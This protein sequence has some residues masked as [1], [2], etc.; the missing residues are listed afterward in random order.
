MKKTIMAMATVTVVGLSGVFFTDTIHAA[1]DLKEIKDERSE[2]KENLTDAESKIADVLIDLKEINEEIKQSE[3]SLQAN[4]EATEDVQSEMDELNKEIDVLEDAIEERFDILKERA[5]SYQRSGGNIAYLDVI[6]GSSSF[7]EFISRVSAV[8]KIADS[9]A[10][11]IE[12]QEADKAEVEQKLSEL[13]DLK[14]EL[15]E[16]EQLILEQKEANE[17]RKKELKGKEKELKQLKSK[18]Q[19]KD[20]KLAAL[21]SEIYASMQ[22]AKTTTASKGSGGSSKAS[23][24][25]RSVTGGGA[26]GWPTQGGYISSHMGTRGGRMHKGMD[27]ART[28]RSTSP[29]IFAADGG[30]VASA[31]HSGAY[32]NKVVIN[33]NNGMKT[34]YAHLSSI[35]VSAGQSVSRGTKIGI[36]GRTGRSTG[37]HLHFEVYVNGALQNPAK[38][39]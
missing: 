39:F 5:K 19:V 3:A 15:K 20:K 24:P 37:I 25:D 26:L 6:L 27:I 12:Q 28:D 16:M 9:D 36:M 11:L 23:A 18:L 29:P 13:N 4:Q 21:E 17:Q 31:G 33:H 1:G 10:E 2:I 32:G 7:G 22:P 14:E 34:V 30:T 35:N 8:S 38:Y